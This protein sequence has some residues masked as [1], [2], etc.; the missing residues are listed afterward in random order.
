[1]MLIA[2]Y[3]L[4]VNNEDQCQRKKWRSETDRVSINK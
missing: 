3:R 4:S 1:M 2:H